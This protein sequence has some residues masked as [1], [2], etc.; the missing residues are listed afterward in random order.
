VLILFVAESPKQNEIN[1]DRT[2]QNKEI[3]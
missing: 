2:Q 3:K 1:K